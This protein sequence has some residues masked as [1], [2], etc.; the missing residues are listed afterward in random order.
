MTADPNA[1]FHWVGLASS[2]PARACRFY[3]DVFGWRAELR[4]A[5]E[6][7]PCT[8]FRHGSTDTALVYGQ[9]R[10]ARAAGVLPHWT[11]FVSSE[12]LEES[13]RRARQLGARVLRA[14]FTVPGL[15]CAAAVRD[16]VGGIVALWR[17]V[18]RVTD[19]TR[20][21]VSAVWYELV[22]SDPDRATAFYRELF[23]W[24]VVA[25]D[26]A[27]SG[28][29]RDGLGPIGWIRGSSGRAHAPAGG[30]LPYFVVEDAESALRRA[31]RVG[32]AALRP[33]TVDGSFALADPQ[34]AE[35]AVVDAL[36]LADVARS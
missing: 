32:G 30:W 10:E 14:P 22:T 15:G 5:G 17:P 35:F 11:P 7:G 2:D 4:V 26:G 6:L 1:A 27:R 16:P 25:A 18:A 28:T 12:D 19:G 23:G 9:T 24:D 8:V 29:I 36:K 21:R 33:G 20:G 3:S 34:G 13:L 31:D